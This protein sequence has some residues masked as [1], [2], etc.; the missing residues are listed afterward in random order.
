MLRIDMHDTDPGIQQRKQVLD[1]SCLGGMIRK[2]REKLGIS[3]LELA[4]IAGIDPGNLSKIE[5]GIRRSHLD[6][7]MKL[8]R[9][10]G[11]DIFAEERSR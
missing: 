11:I 9:L 5:R 7:Y 10:L 3:Q 8:C 6:T 4:S 1:A 2:R